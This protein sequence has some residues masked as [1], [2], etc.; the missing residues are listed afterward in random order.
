MTNLIFVTALILSPI[1]RQQGCDEP[2]DTDWLY[3]GCVPSPSECYY[4]CPQLGRYRAE[5]DPD[6]C[7]DPVAEWACYCD[8]D[9]Y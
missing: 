1:A 3:V 4:S 7:I 8:A 2:L 5:I 9:S 6:L